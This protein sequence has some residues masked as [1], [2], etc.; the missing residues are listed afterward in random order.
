M[1]FYSFLEKNNEAAA[2]SI[3]KTHN[4]NNTRA[5]PL[6]MKSVIEDGL[7]TDERSPLIVITEG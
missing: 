5:P 3:N 7:K 6:L 4:N 2:V 1:Q